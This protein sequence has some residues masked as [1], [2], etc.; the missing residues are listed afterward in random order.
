MLSA[1]RKFDAEPLPQAPSQ[2]AATTLVP[3]LFAAAH[4]TAGASLWCADEWLQSDLR[5]D[6][7]PSGFDALDLE[8]PGRGWPQGQLVELLCD[9]P[10]VG[11]LSLL[12]PALG[13]VSRAGRTCV[14]VLP[15]QQ[16]GTAADSP[17]QPQALPYAPALQEAGIDLARNIF[18]RPL[19]PRESGWALEQS[20]RAPHLGALLG[21]L[22]EGNSSDADFRCLRRLHLLAQR[23]R[24]LVF[25]L[26]ASRHA[27]SPSP[28]ALRLQLQHA[29]GQLQLRLLK[30]RSRPLLE[31]VALQIH[32]AGWNTSAAPSPAAEPA[33]DPSIRSSSASPLPALLQSVRALAHGPGW[34]LQPALGL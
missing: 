17:A 30:R 21:W 2:R 20:L 1:I 27:S 25:I 5:P 13:A 34:A 4:A 19:T 28:A 22:P 12:L 6:C 29:S 16:G 9:R 33:V 23:H 32:P 24:A 18:V 15:C 8:L 11:E 7:T 14:W 3:S 31:P 26:R 10:G